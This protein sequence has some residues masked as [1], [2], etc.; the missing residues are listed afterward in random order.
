V[1]RE[2]LYYSGAYTFNRFRAAEIGRGVAAMLPGLPVWTAATLPE[3]ERA[4]DL[5]HAAPGPAFIELHC[6]PDEIPPFTPF[7]KELIA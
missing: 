7:L 4:L 2:R 5:S 1:A 6:D 3:F